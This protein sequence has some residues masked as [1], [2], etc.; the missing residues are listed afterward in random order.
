MFLLGYRML[1]NEQVYTSIRAK[2]YQPP[3]IQEWQEIR[4]RRTIG[5]TFRIFAVIIWG[6]QP[7][8]LKYTPAGQVH[9][10]LLV[11]LMSA[12]LLLATLVGIGGQALFSL[13]RIPLRIPWNIHLINVIIGQALFLYFIGSS[14]RITSSTNF[15]LLSNF[16]PVIALLVATVLWRHQ[17]PYLRDPKHVLWI[18][19]I[20]LM[21]ST[22]SSLIIY[23]SIVRNAATVQGD[24]LALLAMVCDV[25]LITAQIR[26]IK[27]VPTASPMVINLYIS[28]LLVVG[29]FPI[30]IA[31]WLSGSSLL[32]TVTTPGILFSLGAGVQLAIGIVF[33][34]EA[35]RRIDGFIAFLMFNVSILINFVGEVMLLGTVKPTILFLIG[36]TIIVASTILAEWI[37][38]HCEK[39]GT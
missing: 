9:P 3:T 12:G 26:Y 39:K 1:Q 29:F 34:F 13:K 5:Y 10:V 8:Y 37:N 11:Y 17:I 19:A 18:F 14:L 6:L 23:N 21:G 22:G 30:F 32:T 20:F 24:V 2:K 27:L 38:S 25:L 33:N 16:S 31:L 35:F 36:A 4:R 28:A 7:L 15:A